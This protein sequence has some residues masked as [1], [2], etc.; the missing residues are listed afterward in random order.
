MHLWYISSFKE[1]CDRNGK[2]YK[3]EWDKLKS[4]TASEKTSFTITLFLAIVLKGS[5][6]NTR[7]LFTVCLK[8]TVKMSKSVAPCAG[9]DIY[10]AL[11]SRLPKMLPCM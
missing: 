9:S 8:L 4:T 11:T 5:G 3:E 1:Y 10:Q 2:N 7:N 6:F